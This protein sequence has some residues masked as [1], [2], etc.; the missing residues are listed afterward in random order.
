MSSNIGRNKQ[1]NWQGKCTTAHK[2]DKNNVNSFKEIEPS[3]TMPWNNIV[4]FKKSTYK[5]KK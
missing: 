4:L 2:P 5:E 1:M 3:P